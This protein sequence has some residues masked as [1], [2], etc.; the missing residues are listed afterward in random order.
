MV[1]DLDLKELS[2]FCGY[3]YGTNALMWKSI[4]NSLKQGMERVSMMG[5]MHVSIVPFEDTNYAAMK[6]N[7]FEM[8]KMW[9]NHVDYTWESMIHH[10]LMLNKVGGIMCNAS[11]GVSIV[12]RLV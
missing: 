6:V 5:P 1:V 11:F 3:I 8:Q 2:N 9:L 4:G 10:L 12:L 7:I